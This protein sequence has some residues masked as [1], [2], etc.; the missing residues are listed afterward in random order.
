MSKKEGGKEQ[1]ITSLYRELNNLKQKE[2]YEKAIKTCNRILHLD[3]NDSLAFHC[4]VVALIHSG[5]FDDA[6]KQIDGC[7]HN[8]DLSFETAY[9][10]YRLN[11]LQKSLKEIDSVKNPGMKHQE[12][13]AQILYKLEDYNQCF[14]LYRNIVKN[15]TDEF[16]VE[17]KT[18]ISAVIT[19]L[20]DEANITRD[21]SDE[22]YELRYNH[23]CGLAA[24]EEYAEAEQELKEAETQAREFLKEEGEGEEEIEEEIG[25]IKVQMAYVLQKQGKEKEAQTLYN[26]V[27]KN[28]PQ[29]I[30]LVAVASNNLLTLNRD[31]NIFDSKKRLKA[32]TAEGLEGK[33][34]SKQRG[35]IARNQAL[36]A[37]F[38]AQV[39]LCKQLV[40]QLDSNIIPDKDYIIAGVL[41]KSGKYGEAVSQLEGDKSAISQLTSAHILLNAGE[42]KSALS[43]LEGLPDTWKYRHGVLSA[44]VS[45]YLALDDRPKAAAALKKATEWN[46]KNKTSGSSDMNVVWRK[47]AEFHM[48]SGEPEVAAKSLEEML[49]VNSDLR[50]LAQLVL[51]YAKF[52][53]N[54][55]MEAA[56]KLPPFDE[57]SMNV[58]I[59][60]L[61]ESAFA[62]GKSLKK[63]P[64]TPKTPKTPKKD[65]EGGVVKKKSKKRKKR[66]PKNY[67]PNATPDPERWLPRRERTGLKYLPGQRRIRKDKRKGEKFTGGQGVASGQTETYDYSGKVAAAATASPQPEPSGEKQPGPRQQQKKSTSSKAKKKGGKKVF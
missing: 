5:K 14:N 3:S 41:A 54:K 47:T 42:V 65:E 29:D 31:Q 62:M 37:M 15:S 34:T 21:G 19:Q 52:D 49:R 45:L 44:L 16:E 58:D 60:S 39:D 64:L 24:I 4:K 40:D 32:A 27:L 48:S 9:C 38:T 61:E 67:D 36:L 46:L 50:T 7:K 2:E 33:L 23:G 30:G 25:I 8:L 10:Y 53:L 20:G 11:Q 55:A 22:S 66:L 12:L 13:K 18:N 59:G 6:L 28:K 1:D 43:H 57:E 63:N 17:R 26:A 56:K 35:Q 51:A